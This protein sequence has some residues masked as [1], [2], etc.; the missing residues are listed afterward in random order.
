MHGLPEV[1]QGYVE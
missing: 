1:M